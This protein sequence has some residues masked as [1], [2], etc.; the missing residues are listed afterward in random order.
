MKIVISGFGFSSLAFFS[1]DEPGL[2]SLLN[3]DAMLR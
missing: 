3:V 2:Q 1:E